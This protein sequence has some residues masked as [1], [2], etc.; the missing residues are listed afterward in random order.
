MICYIVCYA[1]IENHTKKLNEIE[2]ILVLNSYCNLR[3]LE[4]FRTVIILKIWYKTFDINQ[5]TTAKLNYRMCKGR[6]DREDHFISYGAL[7]LSVPIFKS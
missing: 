3:L 6:E 4:G 7:F 2:A 1:N 5:Q